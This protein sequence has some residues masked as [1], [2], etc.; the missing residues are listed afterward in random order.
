MEEQKREAL[1]PQ[2]MAAKLAR[3]HFIEDLAEALLVVAEEVINTGKKGGVSATFTIS[4]ATKGEPSVVINEEIKRTAPKR[5]P[6]GKL[7][8]LGED[9][10]YE[11]DPRQ[12]QMDFTVIESAPAEVR[13]I[14]ADPE[15]RGA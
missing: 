4:Q 2:A 6:L 3:G 12:Q 13:R 15:V 1:T 11:R 10:F 9:G 5:D 14:E 7:L 8:Y